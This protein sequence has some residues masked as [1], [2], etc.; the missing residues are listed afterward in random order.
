MKLIGR[1]IVCFFAVLGI[2]AN[3][4]DGAY[5]IKLE[6]EYLGADAYGETEDKERYNKG[7]ELAEMLAKKGV[8]REALNHAIEFLRV[9]KPPVEHLKTFEDLGYSI[10]E[11][12]YEVFLDL[13][14]TI[15]YTH[16]YHGHNSRLENRIR[17]NDRFK[18]NPADRAREYGVNFSN[19]VFT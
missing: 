5:D 6:K 2:H 19:S 14:M 15:T 17:L 13:L 7:M 1:Q 4:A 11:I 12:E 8:D 3:A 10:E 16:G 9:D 18:D